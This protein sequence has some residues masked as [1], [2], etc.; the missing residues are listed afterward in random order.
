MGNHQPVLTIKVCFISHSWSS[1]SYPL[2][3]RSRESFSGAEPLGKYWGYLG[4]MSLGFSLL[5]GNTFPCKWG[6]H[7]RVIA[8]VEFASCAVT[9]M[10]HRGGEELGV[11]QLFELY[12]L[13]DQQQVDKKDRRKGPAGWVGWGERWWGRFSL[14]FL[15]WDIPVGQLSRRQ[16]KMRAW[17]RSSRVHLRWSLRKTR[18]EDCIKAVSKVLEERGWGRKKREKYKERR[19]ERKWI[20]RRGNNWLERPAHEGDG[21]DRLWSPMEGRGSSFLRGRNE[22]EEASRRNYRTFEQKRWGSVWFLKSDYVNLLN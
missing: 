9:R 17:T 11:T 10:W 19:R 7:L 20:T 16:V 6:I 4:N 21:A 1:R 14:K 8:K 18:N 15:E 3:G 12:W 5:A 22:E 13:K 2:L